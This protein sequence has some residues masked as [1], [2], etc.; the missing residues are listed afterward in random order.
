MG[1]GRRGGGCG[2]LRR[3][4]LPGACGRSQTPAE[5]PRRYLPAAGSRGSPRAPVARRCPAPHLQPAA[6]ASQAGAVRSRRALGAECDPA[7]GARPGPAAARR[8]A[9]RAA[10]L[11]RLLLLFCS[12][13]FESFSFCFFGTWRFGS[14]G[15]V[16]LSSLRVLCFFSQLAWLTLTRC[17]RAVNR[18]KREVPTPQ[19]PERA[20][21]R[22]PKD[23]RTPRQR[24]WQ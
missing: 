12:V 4:P 2:H 19:R 15:L 18:G 23:L 16:R 7:L 11:S 21:G 8:D 5:R 24:R 22:D 1:A 6:A 9:A 14:V 17:K 20:S 3:P 13:C 10:A